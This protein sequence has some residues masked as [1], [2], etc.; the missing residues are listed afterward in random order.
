M[1]IGFKHQKIT[2]NLSKKLIVTFVIIVFL[3]FSILYPLKYFMTGPLIQQ[4]FDKLS[5]LVH[6]MVV[7]SGIAFSLIFILT[8]YIVIKSNVKKQA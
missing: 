8:N 5:L 3:V 2:S 1:E 4:G 6:P 7:I